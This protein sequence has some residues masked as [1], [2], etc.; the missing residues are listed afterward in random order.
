MLSSLFI[1]IATAG[2]VNA[3]FKVQ[4]T[5]PIVQE[6][7]DPILSPGTA[8]QHLHT[9]HG[10][11]NFSMNE[12]YTSA[13]Q[14]SCTSCQVAQDLSNYWVPTLYFKDP[15]NGTFTKVPNGGLL[16]YYENRGVDAPIN[17]GKGLT[18]FPPGF[19]MLSGNAAKRSQKYTPGEGSQGELAER[20][21]IGQCLRYTT[22][23][24]GY[25]FSGF[26]TTDCEAG[27]NARLQMPSCWDGVN[28]WLPG[29]THVSY[30]SGL[31][32]GECDAAHP[33]T[34]VH[35]FYEITWDLS[36]FR[37]SWVPQGY[38]WPFVY[39]NSDPTGWGWHGDFFNGWNVPVLQNALDHCDDFSNPGQAGGLASACPYLNVTTADTA[40]ACKIAKVEV[41][42]PL[43][44]QGPLAALPGCNPLQYGPCDATLYPRG[45]SPCPKT[46]P[47]CG[48]T[49]TAITSV[50]SKTSTSA[51]STGTVVGGSG[52]YLG[53]YSDAA[54]PRTL[55]GST[56]TE[57]TMTNP[58]CV[59]TCRSQ[60]Y[61][62]AGTEYSNECFCGNSLS[63]GT[64]MTDGSCNGPCAGDSSTLCGGTYRLSVYHV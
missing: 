17:G 26:P 38:P 7:V 48:A 41:T 22:S 42:E 39:S 8:S 44:I 11:N 25:A 24:P 58:S 57:S 61:T 1:G 51:A 40:S 53:C 10:G 28:L 52:T 31:D 4:C 16:A 33:V 62:Y 15:V 47:A 9:I 5:L 59:A 50:T 56:T 43:G 21:L 2:V 55:T 35:L 29:S 45:T 36:P 6:F 60:G 37:S 12:T 13:T 46:G 49:T 19:R 18:A 3:F 64:I 32:N 63:G 14:S 23:N 20:A 30:L 27:L 34:L 54:S